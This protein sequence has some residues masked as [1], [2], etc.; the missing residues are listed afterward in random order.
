M[1]E[2]T[3]SIN[4]N[5]LFNVIKSVFGIIYP[6]ITFPYISRVLMTENVGKINYGNSIISYFAL[7]AS[8]GISTYAIRECARVRDDKEQLEKTASQLLSINMVTTLIS[9]TILIVLLIFSS[10]LESYRLLICIQS[11]NI[12]FTTIGAD[13]LNTAMEDFRYIAVRTLSMQVISLTLMFVFVHKPEDYIRYALIAVVA[14]SGA[15]I[16]NVYYRRRFCRVHLTMDMDI[17]RHLPPIMMLFSLLLS[18]TIY[19]NSDMTILGLLKGDLQV[20]LYST[21]VKIYTLVNMTIASVSLVVMP[22]LSEGFAKKDFSQINRL[23]K[24]SLNFILILGIP[25]LCGIEVISPHLIYLLAGDQ[26][27]AAAPALRILGVALICSLIGGWI[28]NCTMIPAGREDICL[29]SSI[30]C[31]LVNIVLNIILIPR[32]GLMA[33]A[34]TTSLS[35]FL[36]ICIMAPN[37]DKNVRIEGL[38]QMLKGPLIGGAGIVAIGIAAQMLIE[39]AWVVSVV[40]IVLSVIWYVAVLTVTRNEFFLDFVRPVIRKIT[41]GKAE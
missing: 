9:Y 17:R 27:L 19:V 36:A 4:K 20:G 21:A 15:N 3:R 24:Y 41:G 26:Y 5:T 10:K 2:S 1:S 33:A 23:L 35:E 31:A 13:W 8:L 40:T 6:L 38:G 11:C 18:Q 25:S 16:F 29:K 34:L 7:I 22:Q 39:K 37:I 30:I 28:G 12:L 14:T 32:W